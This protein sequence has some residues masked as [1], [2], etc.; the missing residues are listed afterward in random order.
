MKLNSNILGLLR[1][2]FFFIDSELLNIRSKRSKLNK[3]L[4]RSG[5]P[6]KHYKLDLSKVSIAT[7][8]SKLFLYIADDGNT[9]F[10]NFFLSLDS[11]TLVSLKIFPV[12]VDYFSSK[13]GNSQPSFYP[14]HLCYA[15]FIATRW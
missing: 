2:I 14:R 1:E 5:K 13:S 11:K 12:H 9:D 6:R 8:T 3:F 10:Y 7:V 4:L 15:E